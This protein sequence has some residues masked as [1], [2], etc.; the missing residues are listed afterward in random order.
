MTC[1]KCRSREE[2]CD[3]GKPCSACRKRNI[4]ADQCVYENWDSPG[5][6]EERNDDKYKDGHSHELEALFSENEALKREVEVLKARLDSDSTETTCSSQEPSRLELVLIDTLRN[7]TDRTNFYGP[8]CWRSLMLSRPNCL[9]LAEDTQ[10]Y[11][12]NMK[13]QWIMK[14]GL[15]TK[16]PFEHYRTMEASVPRVLLENLSLHLPEFEVVK[17][18]LD[19]FESSFWSQLMPIVDQQALKKDFLELFSPRHQTGKCEI[20]TFTKIVDF[21]RIALIVIVF[22]YVTLS[23]NLSSN[24][25]QFDDTG[26]EFGK[27]CEDVV[28]V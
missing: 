16:L 23:M 17:S 9:E 11:L 4:S 20:K 28:K 8:T 1:T 2:K 3:L 7:K 6:D 27:I 10:T 15:Q 18:Y 14:M 5:D 26:G 25:D 21:A 19:M 24:E 13:K 22:K 12:S